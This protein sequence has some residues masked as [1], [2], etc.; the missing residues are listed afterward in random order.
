M[1]PLS[2][3]VLLRDTR[4]WPGYE[5][6]TILPR[7][8][9]RARVQPVR[10]D[11]SGTLYV[12]ADHALEGVDAVTL[13]DSPLPGWTWRNGADLTGHGVAF[14]H[15][16]TAPQGT[17]A[18]EVR[19]LPG[20]PA[21][22]LRDLYPHA[23]LAE[24]G[25]QCQRAGWR[26]G[27]ALTERKTLRAT[28]QFVL[29]QVG[30]AWSAGMPGFAA[31][32]PPPETD[33]TWATL[34]RTEFADWTAECSL[35]TVVT[36]VAVSFD[37]DQAANQARQSVVLVAPA[38]EA[39][40]GERPAEWAMPWVRDARQAVATATT[41]LQWRSRPLWTLQFSTGPRFRELPPGGWIVVHHPRLPLS[42]RYVV[43]DL[44]PGIGSGTVRVTAQAAAGLV[45]TIA[46]AQSS[47][48]F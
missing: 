45:P 26:L 3:L 15:L 31:P 22:I 40:H 13:D 21:D 38:A 12:L 2:D 4:V 34:E 14:L 33:P 19:G 28:L 16:A 43:T 41:W 42:G 7:V 48:A 8:Y 5:T 29:E 10:Y 23:D 32:F 37:W 17:L 47:T 20:N 24:F 18:A 11:A 35:D 36:R 27:G 25:R 39:M 46:L 6:L 44:D 9:G 30:C 1:R